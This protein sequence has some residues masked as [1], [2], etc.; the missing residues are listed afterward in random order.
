MSVINIPIE[1]SPYYGD[2]VADFASLPASGAIGEVI[3]TLDTGTFYWWDGATWQETTTAP[4]PNLIISAVGVVIDGGGSV[5]TTGSKGYAVVPY[6][7]TVSS[8]TVLADQALSSVAVDVKRSTYTNFPSTVS[9]VGG[10]GNK[11]TLSNAQK[12]QAN[13]TSWTST[14]ITAGDVLEFNVDSASTATRVT[15]QLKLTRT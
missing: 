5:I 4:D 15:V 9:I 8:W 3:L 1:S 14:A 12:N 2:P 11:P 7:A 13:P 6:G 10:S